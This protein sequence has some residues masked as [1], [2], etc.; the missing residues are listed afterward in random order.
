VARRADG[1]GRPHRHGACP[2]CLDTRYTFRADEPPPP[3]DTER[4]PR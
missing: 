2:A 1:T 3:P 4:I